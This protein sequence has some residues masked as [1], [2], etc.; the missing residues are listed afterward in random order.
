MGRD[1]ALSD[2]PTST[3]T[4][5]ANTLGVTIVAPTGNGVGA[6]TAGMGL[7]S[8]ATGWSSCESSLGG[9][10]CPGGYG[11]GSGTT[12]TATTAG[13]TPSIEAKV[14]ASGAQGLAKGERWIVLMAFFLL[15]FLY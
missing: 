3:S 2:C 1:C 14:A 15:C 13:A 6:A 9:G 5:V 8:C 7:G 11:C 12:C 4:T 10:C